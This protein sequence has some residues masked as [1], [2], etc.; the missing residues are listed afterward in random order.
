[1][2]RLPN[3]SVLGLLQGV[4]VKTLVLTCLDFQL[5]IAQV[6]NQ[7][8][9]IMTVLGV[10]LERCC[11]QTLYTICRQ[12]QCSGVKQVIILTHTTCQ[13]HQNL[14]M[15]LDKKARWADLSDKLRENLLILRPDGVFILDSN[16][17]VLSH[18]RNQFS[19]LEIVLEEFCNSHSINVPRLR[20]IVAGHRL[21]Y[22]ELIKIEI[23]NFKN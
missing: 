23:T 15:D 6:K 5:K 13:V 11:E 21:D 17:F 19:F 1:M 18:T 12:I 10:D 14:L 22:K 3:K 2:N 9:S 20:A 8:I 7:Q 4:R 16:K